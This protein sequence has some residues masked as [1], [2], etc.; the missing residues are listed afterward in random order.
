MFYSLLKKV[1]KNRKTNVQTEIRILEGILIIVVKYGS[2][3]WAIRK[4]MKI[5]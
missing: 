4:V 3:V 2:E 5:Y 1:W